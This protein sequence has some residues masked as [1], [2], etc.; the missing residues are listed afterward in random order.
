MI[1]LLVSVF[2]A[3]DSPLIC[4]ARM[5]LSHRRGHTRRQASEVPEQEGLSQGETASRTVEAADFWHQMLSKAMQACR[6]WQLPELLA[7][8]KA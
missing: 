7:C 2:P 4:T 3:P 8:Q 5:M 1:S 6:M